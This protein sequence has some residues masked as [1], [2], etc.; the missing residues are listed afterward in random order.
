MPY[1]L[2]YDFAIIKERNEI[3]SLEPEDR[4]HKYWDVATT[5]L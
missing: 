5:E 1:H 3:D 4:M 2:D